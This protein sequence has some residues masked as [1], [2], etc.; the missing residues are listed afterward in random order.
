MED[1]EELYGQLKAVEVEMEQLRT[2]M[3]EIGLK[4]GLLHTEVIEMS[5]Q[6]DKKIVA[7]MIIKK[8]IE[9]QLKNRLQK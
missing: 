3:E 4:M 2:K 9:E 5:Q 1:T 7:F 8:Q 6:L